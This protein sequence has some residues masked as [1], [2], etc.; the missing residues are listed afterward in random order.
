MKARDQLS[1]QNRHH[2]T[3]SPQSPQ[4]PSAHL[5][6]VAVQLVDGLSAVPTLGQLPAPK[7]M[8]GSRAACL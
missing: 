7:R 2:I 4:C 6:L 1:H 5:H 8:G 3:V